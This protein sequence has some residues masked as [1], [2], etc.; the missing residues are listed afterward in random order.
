MLGKTENNKFFLKKKKKRKAFFHGRSTCYSD[1]LH[2]FPITITRC[3]KDVYVNSFFPHIANLWI[4]LSI[5]YFPLIYDLNGFKSRINEPFNCRLFLNR[6]SICFDLFV[7][8]FAVTPCLV[9][10]VFSLAW[11]ESQLKKKSHQTIKK[12]PLLQNF[13]SSL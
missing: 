9:V 3:V 10:A 12:S 5:E 11:S 4:S 6:F 1:R 8:L 7:L 2:Y 13:S